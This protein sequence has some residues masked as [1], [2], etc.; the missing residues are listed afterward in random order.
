MDKN[1]G[2]NEEQRQ[3]KAKFELEVKESTERLQKNLPAFK[4]EYVQLV[5]KYGIKHKAIVKFDP[6]IGMIPVLAQEECSV[7]LKH[8]EE[9]SRKSSIIKPD[10]GLVSQR[11]KA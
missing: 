1:K 5:K 11:P 10:E 2:L 4:E 3:Q 6:T 7:E 9:Q 8:M